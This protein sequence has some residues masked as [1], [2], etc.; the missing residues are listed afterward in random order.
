MPNT[1]DL[2]EFRAELVE[3]AA[4]TIYA[5][6]TECGKNCRTC[7]NIRDHAQNTLKG[8]INHMVERFG[9]LI[10]QLRQA[11]QT[12]N[13]VNNL[14]QPKLTMYT[15]PCL[16]HQGSNMGPDVPHSCPSCRTMSVLVCKS[17]DEA[18]W[19]CDTHLILHGETRENC[20][21]VC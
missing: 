20:A 14:H 8:L 19:P 1:L 18:P 7:Q 13:L 21:H 15:S 11:Q 12:I 17:K 5:H 3:V 9:E 6:Y 16:I 2:S 4:K 10:E